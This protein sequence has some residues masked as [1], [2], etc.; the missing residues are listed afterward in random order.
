MPKTIEELRQEAR[1][2][3]LNR[4]DV[5]VYL[6]RG[7][8]SDSEAEELDNLILELSFAPAPIQ[9]PTRRLGCL[10]LD[11]I[12]T[13][14]SA[15][16]GMAAGAQVSTAI[17]GVCDLPVLSLAGLVGGLFASIAA[18]KIELGGKKIGIIGAMLL[19]LLSSCSAS[20]IAGEVNSI[21]NASALREHCL[22]VQRMNLALPD[23]CR[24][25]L[26][27]NESAAAA[28][29]SMRIL[30]GI[31]LTIVSIAIESV[32]VFLLIRWLAKRGLTGSPQDRR[33]SASSK[34]TS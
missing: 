2:G 3:S 20:Q 19:A 27:L 30:A 14:V 29:R 21:R 32:V 12:P 23:A 26:E 10:R 18:R 11:W 5:T 1:Q 6:T 15:L 34:S 22:T 28:K 7:W 33:R 17:P 9:Q 16:A 4:N 31:A 25:E 13:I 8:V 24:S